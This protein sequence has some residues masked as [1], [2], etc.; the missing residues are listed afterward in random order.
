MMETLWRDIRYGARML[1]KRPGFTVVTVLALA[2][3]IGANSAIFSVVNTVLLRPLPYEDPERLVMVWER[4]PRQNRDAGAVAPAD[5]LDWQSQN[6]VFDSMAAYTSTAFNMTGVGEPEQINSQ[7]VTEGFFQVLSVKAALGRTFIQ[8][9]DKEGGGRRLVMGH[10]LWQRRF[11]ADPNIIGRSLTLNNESFTVIGVMPPDFQYPDKATELWASPKR[12]L[13]EVF[14]PGNPDPSTIRTL[15]YLNV[16]AR[17]KPGVTREQAQAEMETIAGRLE[18]QYPAENTGHTARIVALHEQLVGDVRPA[19]LVL[20]AAVG[21][22]LLVACANVANLLLARA[23]ARHKEMSIRTALGAGRLRLIRQLLT[24]SI[25]LSLLG[26]GLGLLLA[27]WGV[28]LLVAL[29]P[30]NLPRLREISLDGKVVGFTLGISLLTGIIFGLAPALQASRLD[31]IG[32]LKEG[33][34]SSMEGFGRHRMRSLLI[35]V[36]VALALVLLTGAGLMIRSFQ[37]IQQVDPGFNPNNLLAVEL[38]LPRS[39]YVE[40]ERMADFY[41]RVT[42]RIAT[43]PGVES[44]GA[45]WTLPLSGQD[46]SRGFDIEGYTPAPNE[47]TNSAFSAVSPRYF[48]TMEIP[49]KMGREFNDRDTAAGPGV[50]IVNDTFARRYFPGGDAVGKRMRLKGEEN[51]WLTI[52]GVVGDVKHTELTAE[53]RTEMYLSSL[54]TAFPF[55]NMVVRTTTDPASLTTAIRK[56]VWAVD[57]DQPVTQVETMLQLISASVARARFNTLL[58][59]VFAAVALILAAIGLYGVISYSV[60]QRTHEIG[61]R[62]ALGAQRSDVLK[63]I[64]GQGMILALAG[65]AIGLAAAFALT[66]LMS[67]LLYGVTATDP[68]T[69]GAVAV[70]L[71]ATALLATIIPAR[72][73]MRVD[74]LV[75]L[76]Y[77]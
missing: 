45:T 71:S 2:L 75:A 8:G 22:V 76:R 36:E 54:Q 11:G 63:L 58:L 68:W 49:L 53:P 52:V 20:L 47:R 25:L 3:G 67:S 40:Q 73:A 65:V 46:A 18:Q 5:F 4:R 30:G 34:R 1:A 60:T 21:F 51:P 62:M 7:L 69:F 42:A 61:I 37:R 77:E 59:G 57:S 35:V 50:I 9:E 29:S 48:Q 23:T 14:L 6:Q 33:G 13:P 41:S 19:L 56:E 44:V 70:I 31:L 38:S 39:K 24:E 43:L 10:G 17:L 12:V 27:L 15:H 55:M 28:D 26:G 32:S 66:R 72:R 16:I 64:V 74:P